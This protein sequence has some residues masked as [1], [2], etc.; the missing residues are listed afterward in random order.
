MKY[1]M[2]IINKFEGKINTV[3]INHEDIYWTVSFLLDQLEDF[4][5]TYN[6]E[7]IALL[8][9][10]IENIKD[11]AID[12]SMYDIEQDIMM[13]LEDTRTFGYEFESYFQEVNELL[14]ELNEVGNE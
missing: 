10:D 8:A 6:D 13:N 11:T 3:E 1:N 9:G 2:E 12:F 4:D 5:I 14:T 7:V